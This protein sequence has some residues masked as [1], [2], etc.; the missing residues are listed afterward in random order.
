[1]GR[2]WGDTVIF[3]PEGM[4]MIMEDSITEQ[5]FHLS[6]KLQVSELLENFPVAL[7]TGITTGGVT[8]ESGIS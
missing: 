6:G 3:I 1:V 2:L 7:L 5:R 4:N 8:D